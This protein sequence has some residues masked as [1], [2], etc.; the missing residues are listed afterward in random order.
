[1]I[2]NLWGCDEGSVGAKILSQ[3]PNIGWIGDRGA[4]GDALTFCRRVHL[5]L[6]PFR[7]SAMWRTVQKVV[8]CGNTGN[9]ASIYAGRPEA[10]QLPPLPFSLRRL[11]IRA[12]PRLRSVT[13]FVTAPARLPLYC[14]SSSPLPLP[15]H[16]PTAA[17]T[18]TVGTACALSPGP[19]LT[20]DRIAPARCHPR[21]P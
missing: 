6:L 12:S 17:V 5:C 20:T 9:H 15:P 19:W 2:T 10:Y 1:V 8:R 3:L 11:K 16:H 14:Q 7:A 21:P 13:G 4:V 18:S